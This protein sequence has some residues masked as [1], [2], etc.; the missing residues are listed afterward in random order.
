[1][2]ADHQ[3]SP[4]DTFMARYSLTDSNGFTPN[5]F[6]GYGSLDNQRQMAGTVSYAHIVGTGAVNEFKFGYLRF[7]EYQAAENTIAGRNIV[8]ELGL[9]GFAF[10]NTPGL[11]GAPNFTIGG[12]ATIGDG[13]GPFRPRNNTFQVLD[14]FSFNRGRHF[15]KAGG[16]VRRA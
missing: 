8:K 2:R 4:K 13:D 3:F 14:Q 12:F 7:T 15:I 1:V 10:A 11:Q 6:P 16:E 5:T 9:R